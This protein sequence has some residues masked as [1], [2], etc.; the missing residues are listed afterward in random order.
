MKDQGIGFKQGLVV[1]KYVLVSSF[2]HDGPVDF[3]IIHIQ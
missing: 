3:L 1:F 2:D